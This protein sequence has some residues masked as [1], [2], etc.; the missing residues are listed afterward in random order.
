M[1]WQ[2]TIIRK[3]WTHGP[4]ST[5]WTVLLSA[6]TKLL[7]DL[8]LSLPCIQMVSSSILG[9]LAFFPVLQNVLKRLT[10]VFPK[11]LYPEVTIQWG[12]PKEACSQCRC[13]YLQVPF[14][15][16][17]NCVGINS[18]LS[19]PEN[20]LSRGESILTTFLLKQKDFCL[21]NIF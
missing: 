5:I 18:N 16:K 3:P 20:N 19:A 7:P 12:I 11:C 13:R 15:R 8:K 21:C 9:I 6:E 2:S 1:S 17:A 14:C 4:F 10:L